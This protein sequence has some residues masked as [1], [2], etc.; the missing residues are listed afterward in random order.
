MLSHIRLHTQEECEIYL[1]REV[2]AASGGERWTV[3]ET[4]GW[5]LLA[6][7]SAEAPPGTVEEIPVG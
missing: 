4:R 2:P 7:L 5:R 1:R 6:P 3:E